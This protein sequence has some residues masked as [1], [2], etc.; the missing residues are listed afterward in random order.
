M[1]F[2]SLYCLTKVQ[3][4]PSGCLCLVPVVETWTEG[5]WAFKMVFKV[6]KIGFLGGRVGGETGRE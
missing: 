6:C 1:K 3:P 4:T 5:A 2:I